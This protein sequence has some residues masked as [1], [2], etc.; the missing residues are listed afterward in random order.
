M[1]CACIIQTDRNHNP[2]VIC[3]MR[4]RSIAL[5]QIAEIC[6][7]RTERDKVEKRK[8]F[9]LNEHENPLLDIPADIYQ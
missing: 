8:E 6:A 1:L 3:E 5:L 7:Q 2:D 9:G 4:T